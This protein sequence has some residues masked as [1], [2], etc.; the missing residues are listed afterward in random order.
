MLY[1]RHKNNNSKLTL[2]T[3]QLLILEPRKGRVLDVSYKI[4]NC[5]INFWLLGLEPDSLEFSC[6]EQLKGSKCVLI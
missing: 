1:G 4:I 6:S 2:K 3:L 5:I